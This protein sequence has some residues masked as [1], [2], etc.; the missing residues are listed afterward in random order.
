MLHACHAKCDLRKE[1]DVWRVL[2]NLLFNNLS[3][4]FFSSEMAAKLSA[5]EKEVEKLQAKVSSSDDNV[6]GL[7]SS[8]GTTEGQV[9][10]LQ[11]RQNTTED[12]VQVLQG[13]QNTT[14]N[15]VEALMTA[16]EGNE[17]TMM[18]SRCKQER[19][20]LENVL[21]FIHNPMV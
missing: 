8:L 10:V 6:Q 15:K 1:F 11:G 14:D 9:Q 16:S 19:T 4:I 20:V 18:F 2:A 13:R 17:N 7:Q 5:S 21:F 3:L 12:Q